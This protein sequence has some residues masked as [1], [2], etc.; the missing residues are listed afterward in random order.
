MLTIISHELAGNSRPCCHYTRTKRGPGK[1]HTSHSSDYYVGVVNYLWCYHL[2]LYLL[3]KLVQWWSNKTFLEFFVLEFFIHLPKILPYLWVQ[4]CIEE[5]G[6]SCLT[7]ASVPRN[8]KRTGWI[9]LCSI[10]HPPSVQETSLCPGHHGGST[11]IHNG[12][13]CK[14]WVLKFGSW[15]EK[16]CFSLL[17]KYFPTKPGFKVYYLTAKSFIFIF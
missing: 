5:I 2:T 3:T 14:V 16:K 12:K 15:Y 17:D 13:P 1:L 11:M 4:V 7:A 10:A 6:S 8:C 9:S